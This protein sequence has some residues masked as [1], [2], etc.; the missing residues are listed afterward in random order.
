MKLKATG[1][2][3]TDPEVTHVSLVK[4]PANGAPIKILRNT[5]QTYMNKFNLASLAGAVAAAPLAIFVAQK[6]FDQY[7]PLLEE[8]GYDLSKQELIDDTL[9]IKMAPFEESEV[10][11]V[12][13][14]DDMVFVVHKFLDPYKSGL[15][16]TEKVKATGF[17]PTVRG[18]MEAF[19]DGMYD[20]VSDADSPEELSGAVASIGDDLNAYIT[21]LAGALPRSAFTVMKSLDAAAL[22]KGEDNVDA[23][24]LLDQGAGKLADGEPSNIGDG[25]KLPEAG[26]DAATVGTSDADGTAA[27]D[28]NAD[29]K[30]KDD[31]DDAAGADANAAAAGSDAAGADATGDA[32]DETDAAGDAAGDTAGDAAGADAT[33]NAE[34]AKKTATDEK[35]D[36]MLKT[37]GA[38]TD[39][40]SKLAENQTALGER[41]GEVE[42][43]AKSLRGQA[44][45]AADSDADDDTPDN[46][47]QIRRQVE[48]GGLPVAAET[49]M[50]DSFWSGTGFRS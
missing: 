6:S 17:M 1:K 44:N 22:E 28:G 50:P 47:H 48:F 42:T 19:M 2:K 15:K 27:A 34:P 3:I 14:A 29:D 40:V 10:D 16:F 13:V 36:A 4:D 5:G 37:L 35:L 39:S 23:Q 43:T 7:K 9:V 38:L 18:A 11:A 32:G 46:V 41:I 24:A 31:K 30:D 21:K 20:A 25:T 8:Q 45:A 33:A 26:N 12:H 49:P